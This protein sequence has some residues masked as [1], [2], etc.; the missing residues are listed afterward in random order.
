MI[1]TKSLESLAK[2]ALDTALR[3]HFE[4]IDALLS[5]AKS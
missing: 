1:S 2:R 4:N 3:N 5:F